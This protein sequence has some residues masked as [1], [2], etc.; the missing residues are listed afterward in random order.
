MPHVDE[1]KEEM[2]IKQALKNG[3]TN[4]AK[5]L[6]PGWRAIFKSFSEQIAQARL[7]NLPLSIFE[8]TSGGQATPTT[9]NAGEEEENN[10]T[11]G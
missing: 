7:D 3:T 1:L 2:A 10:N 6:G 4:Y 9:N 11:G 8:M 5:L